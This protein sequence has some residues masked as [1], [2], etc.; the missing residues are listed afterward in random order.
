VYSELYH[1]SIQAALRYLD[2]IRRSERQEAGTIPQCPHVTASCVR[3]MFAAYLQTPLVISQVSVKKDN[4]KT[5]MVPVFQSMETISGEVLFP[6]YAYI[7][8]M[9]S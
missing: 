3:N 9:F 8:T 4:G 5:T 7:N 6:L 2:H 1:R